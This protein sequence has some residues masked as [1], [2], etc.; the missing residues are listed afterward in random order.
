[1][2][3]YSEL[4]EN[5]LC[6]YCRRTII[7]IVCF[8]WGA[9]PKSYTLGQKIKWLK[10]IKGNIIPPYTVRK[11]RDR[12]NSGEPKYEDL[13]VLDSNYFAPDVSPECPQCGKKIDGICIEI[14]GGRIVSAKA[15][16]KGELKEVFGIETPYID[17]IIL[18]NGEFRPRYD[19]YDHS[20]RYAP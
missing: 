16:E 3:E 8:Q 7:S 13:Y 9:T 11:N 4:N 1:M 12:W 15:L 6:P 19:L 17:I 14:K 20:L 10:D 18:E 2:P 5:V